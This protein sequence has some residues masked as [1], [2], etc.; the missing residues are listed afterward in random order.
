MTPAPV[1]TGIALG[2]GAARGLAHIGVL[3]EL[4]AVGIRPDIICGTSIGALVG[5]VAATEKTRIVRDWLLTLTSRDVIR[6][7]G[8]RASLRSGFSDANPLIAKLRQLCGS[9]EIGSLAVRYAAIGTDLA[10]GKELWMQEGDLW[11]AARCSMSLPGLITPAAYDRRWVTDGGLVNPVPVS[12]C[13]ALGA[14]IVIA[15]NLNDD[16]SGR[17]QAYTA[18]LNPQPEPPAPGMMDRFTHGIRDRLPDR[19]RQWFDEEDGTTGVAPLQSED[20]ISPMPGIF[21]IVNNSINIMQDRITRSRLAG[22][23]ADVMIA[24]RL[25]DMGL[26]DFDSAE[27]AIAEGQTAV[28]RALPLLRYVPGLALHQKPA[29]HDQESDPP[30]D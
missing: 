4:E 8:L 19:F 10:T 27:S 22:E 26:L 18:H 12:V 6:Y 23:P 25:N 2:S 29:H 11:D 15:V 13:R 1:K 14:D 24:P 28:R 3:L 16:L 7:L 5:A 20:P 9:P 17:R 21:S 30:A